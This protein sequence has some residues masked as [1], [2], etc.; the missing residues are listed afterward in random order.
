MNSLLKERI[1]YE[2]AMSIG[3]SLDLDIMLRECLATYLRKLNCLA[4]AVLIRKEAPGGL[5]FFQTAYTIPKRLNR[6]S[7]IRTAIENI[8]KSL[9]KEA[10]VHYLHSLPAT[11]LTEKHQTSVMELGG[12]GLLVLIKSAPGLSEPDIKSLLPLNAKLADACRSCIANEQLHREIIEREKA[13]E[14]FRSIFENSVEGI[15][16][17]TIDGVFVEANPSMAKLL[18]YK[19][20]EEL[21]A[22]SPNIRTQLYVNPKDRDRFLNRLITRG[23]V[24]NFEGRFYRRD[25]SIGWGALSARIITDNSNSPMRIEGLFAD[26]SP[27]MKAMEFLRAAKD[28]AVRLSNMKSSFLSMVSHELRTP[29]TSILGF[30]KLAQ[31]Q[32]DDLSDEERQCHPKLARALQRIHN[33]SD[34]I[35]AEGERLTELINNVLDLSKL[36]SG[37]CQWK[38]RGISM[39]EV[40]THSLLTSEILFDGTAVT[41]TQDIEYPLPRVNGDH[42]RLVQVMLNL[43]SNAKKFTEKGTVHVSAGTKD[44]QIVVRV[45]DSGIG[46]PD[47]EREIIFDKFRQSGNTL[48]DKPKGTGLGLAICK[49]IVEHH[50]GTLW[51]E[52][53]EGTGSTFAFTLPVHH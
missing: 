51:L 10:L 52:P 42:D 11:S 6:N 38:M 34:V 49:E 16:Q 27:R 48:T 22:H 7:S 12:V 13:E 20:P 14:K 33:N 19:N 30:A 17:S 31:K 28:E 26:I 4:G 39:N 35:V 25:G 1:Y 29:L 3:N 44:D 46:V 32:I 41:L 18:G 43:I 5:S 50:G 8:P 9:E 45:A 2:I 47:D 15:F 37:S 23:K 40:L 53:N 36:E 24:T 21:L